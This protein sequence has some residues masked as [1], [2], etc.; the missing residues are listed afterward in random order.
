MD[1]SQL[2][3]GK[4]WISLVLFYSISAGRDTVSG[5]LSEFPSADINSH[6]NELRSKLGQLDVSIMWL[7]CGCCTCSSTHHLFNPSALLLHISPGCWR[8]SW[9]LSQKECE[10]VFSISWL[11][12]LLPLS[13]AHL[14]LQHHVSLLSVSGASL[15]FHASLTAA[16]EYC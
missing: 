2:K 5:Y 8:V 11:I 7:T 12:L 6:S 15:T 9:Q 16:Y 1:E 14:Y 10:L 3:V 13:P 4:V